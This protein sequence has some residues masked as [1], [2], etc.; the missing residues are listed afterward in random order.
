MVL[1]VICKLFA[2]LKVPQ[3]QLIE[4]EVSYKRTKVGESIEGLM[5]DADPES[6]IEPEYHRKKQQLFSWRFL[7]AV[8]Y[9]DQ[10]SFNVKTFNGDIDQVSD[11]ILQKS[12]RYVLQQKR[13]S[14]APA[15]EEVKGDEQPA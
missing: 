10:S 9:L 6:Y 12:K 11:A 7:N 1:N 15:D 8:S 4:G 14:Q 3:N 2:D 13:D 5:E